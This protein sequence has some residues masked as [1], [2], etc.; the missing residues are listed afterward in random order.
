MLFTVCKLYSKKEKEKR[1]KRKEQWNDWLVT[2]ESQEI[3]LL[4]YYKCA[5]I[6]L[7]VSL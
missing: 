6:T 7:N 1:K 5:A 4:L 2:L 3:Y